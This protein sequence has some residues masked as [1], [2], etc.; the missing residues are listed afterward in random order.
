MIIWTDLDRK[1]FCE[2]AQ[3]IYSP[4]VAIITTST[5]KNQF[6]SLVIIPRI[7]RVFIEESME[8]T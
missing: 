2:F 4:S 3:L 1:F 5:N 7:F 8:Y 6:N